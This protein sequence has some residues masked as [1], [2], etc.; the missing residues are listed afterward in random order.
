MTEVERLLWREARKRI[1]VTR[2]QYLESL[3]GWTIK[4]H[5]VGYDTVGAALTKG[6]EFHFAT[7]GLK[8]HLSR[9]EIREYLEPILAEH[10]EVITKTPHEDKRQQRFN[11]IIGFVAVGKDEYDIH[12]R[13][14]ELRLSGSRRKECL[15][16][17]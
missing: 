8:W 16:S 13:L 4:P 5:T 7:F 15:S 14:T 1:Y 6:P 9:A 17:Q 10:G 2:D 3:N 11:E 12:Y